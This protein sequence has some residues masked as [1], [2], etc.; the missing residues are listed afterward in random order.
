MNKSRSIIRSAIFTTLAAFLTACGS[1]P[2]PSS[3]PGSKTPD[4]GEVNVY[5]HRHYPV[6]E[7]IF[8]SFTEQTGI[9]VNV[10]KAKADALIVRIKEEGEQS[11][12]DVLVTADAG[13][14][15][16]AKTEGI[17]QSVRSSNLESAI[18]EDRRD[19]EGQWFG[20]TVRA[21]MIA[22]A[23]ERVQPDA[24][25]TYEDLADEKWKGKILVRSSSNIYNQS[26]MAS[27]IAHLGTEKAGAW[28]K[29]VRGNM[30]RP[31]Q[32]SDR[33]QMRAVAA[34]LGDLA[35]VNTYYV[36]L[37]ANSEDEKDRDVA[38]K[39]G[40]FFPNQDDRGTHINISGAGVVKHA[41]NKENAIKLLEFLVSEKV[42]QKYANAN[43]EYPVKI[44]ANSELLNG[45]GEFKADTL[46]LS[47]LGEHNAEAATVFAEAGWE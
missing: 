41:K 22:Y 21:R 47:K 35:V 36:G 19:P 27:L 29:A 43:Y 13:R 20:L 10:V 32:G 39:V 17:L 7:E 42:Q 6:D 15:H 44:K 2:S 18:P 23:K 12:A 9:K 46:N 5:S 11:P 31:P 3:T 38:A 26:L 16:R 30:A 8:A 37:L 33:D 25:S 1:N 34:G 4:A 45:W 14:L 28:A 24:L 40:V